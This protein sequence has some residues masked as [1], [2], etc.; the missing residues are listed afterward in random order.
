MRQGFA[1]ES[2][3]SVM[4]LNLGVDDPREKW[5]LCPP[6][7]GVTCRTCPSLFQAAAE[8]LRLSWGR[9]LFKEQLVTEGIAPSLGADGVWRYIVSDEGRIGI[10]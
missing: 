8:N 6:G 7:N 1:G 3:S 5:R 4:R 9:N 2:A 10:Y